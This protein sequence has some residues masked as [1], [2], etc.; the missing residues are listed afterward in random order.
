MNLKNTFLSAI[1]ATGISLGEVDAQTTNT[2]QLANTTKQNTIQTIDQNNKKIDANCLK[3]YITNKAQ[4]DTVLNYMSDPF[5]MN[6][7]DPTYM[8]MFSKD[9]DNLQSYY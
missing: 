9:L 3:K 6:Q 7:I 8:D 2:N 5:M 1:V 4:L